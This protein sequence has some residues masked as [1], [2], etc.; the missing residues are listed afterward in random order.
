MSSPERVP[1]RVRA[2][3]QSDICPG[4][5]R[6]QVGRVDRDAVDSQELLSSASSTKPFGRHFPSIRRMS[7]FKQL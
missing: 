2:A 7:R 3:S 1:V 5:L 4:R 6:A